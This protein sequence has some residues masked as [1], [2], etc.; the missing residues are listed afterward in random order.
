M[1]FIL[2][3]QFL[4]KNLIKFFI[5][6]NSV[7]AIPISDFKLKPNLFNLIK[8]IHLRKLIDDF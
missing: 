8:H 3:I 2:D 7:S 6:I 4:N 5:I 1:I